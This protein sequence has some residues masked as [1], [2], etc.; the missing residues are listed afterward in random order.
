MKKV[1]L[2]FAPDV[3]MVAGAAAASAGVGIIFLPAGL[4]VAGLFL[5]AAGVLSARG[6]GE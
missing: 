5:I 2:S 3:L 4:I 6:T 1:L